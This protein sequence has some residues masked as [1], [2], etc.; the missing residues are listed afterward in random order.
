MHAGVA[1]GID[2]PEFTGV[3]PIE[4]VANDLASRGVRLLGGAHDGYRRGI[5]KTAQ[6][7]GAHGKTSWANRTP[8]GGTWRATQANS[9]GV[10]RGALRAST[11]GCHV[12]GVAI[13]GAFDHW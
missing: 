8:M 2:R 7:L 5:E 6:K 11:L 9:G 1:L 12:K 13:V 4:K 10:W 3:S